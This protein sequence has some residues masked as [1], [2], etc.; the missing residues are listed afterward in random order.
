M[1]T[2][3]DVAKRAG[4]STATVSKVLSNT[5]YFTEE[6]RLKVERAIK[7][8]GYSPNLPARAL[9]SGKTEIIAVV[10]PYVN[11][12][13]FTDPFVLYMLQGIEAVCHQR[14]YNLLLSTPRLTTAGPDEHYLR[15]I[16][17]HYLDGLIALD[18]VPLASVLEPVHERGIPCIA[19]G[20]HPT[21]H[22]VRTDD[23]GG[24]MQL[25]QHIFDLRHREIG[26]ISV[27][28][29]L[30]F[31][32]NHRLIGMRAATE[33][34]GLDY[35]AFPSAEGDF[36][37][38]SGATEAAVL[39]EQHPHLTAIVCLN[40]RMA[41]GA[42]QHI[43]SVG[44]RVPE[45]ISVIGYDDIPAAASFAPPLTTINNQAPL[46]GQSAAQLLFDL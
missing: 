41:M 1:P 37:I 44:K 12:P 10:F 27:A 5:P 3:S 34:F 32:I 8:V 46:L 33:A 7:E 4:V 38:S 26:I 42:I 39:L 29:T 40:D 31:S 17:S 15:L 20:Y 2:L 22:Y 43:R 21:R 14:G 9:A 11:D 18:N 28:A 45:D 30:N 24:G 19:I 6:T 25:M 36:S 16:Q 35:D 23:H 13:L